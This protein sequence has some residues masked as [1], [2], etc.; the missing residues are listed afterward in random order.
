LVVARAGVTPADRLKVE[1]RDLFADVE[2]ACY[3][4]S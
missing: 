1:C 4:D 2:L 3:S